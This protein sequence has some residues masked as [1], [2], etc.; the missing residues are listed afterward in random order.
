MR[1]ERALSAKMR[2]SPA[3][4]PVYVISDHAVS[5]HT[6]SAPAVRAV[7]KT[8]ILS[9]IC[10]F[11]GNG[12]FLCVNDVVVDLPCRKDATKIFFREGNTNKYIEMVF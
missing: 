7:V 2:P 10:P 1:V 9:I 6:E 4:L 8:A 3:I 5:L 11:T 12:A